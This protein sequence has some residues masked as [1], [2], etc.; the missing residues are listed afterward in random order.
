MGDVAIV[1]HR[2][3][4]GWSPSVPASTFCVLP[5]PSRGEGR[6]RWGGLPAFAFVGVE[7]QVT[8]KLDGQRCVVGAAGWGCS[9]GSSF[10]L[11]PSCF[12]SGACGPWL[13]FAA[14]VHVVGCIQ[15]GR[16]FRWPLSSLA[17]VVVGR[18][19]RWPLSSLAAVVVGRCRCWLL[20]SLAA[21]IFVGRCLR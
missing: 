19:R 6:A 15:G 21:V 5:H 16:C 11:L 17:A 3:R 14:V 7:L 12:V 4:G 18:C 8:W 9:P 20:S 2:L 13:S 10:S 1:S